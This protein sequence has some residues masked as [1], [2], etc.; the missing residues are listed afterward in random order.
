MIPRR[1][2]E[3][4]DVFRSSYYIQAFRRMSFRRSGNGVSVRLFMAR[5]ESHTFGLR[6]I[7]VARDELMMHGPFSKAHSLT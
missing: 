3:S 4:F 6:G 7:P 2:R 1:A 5:D